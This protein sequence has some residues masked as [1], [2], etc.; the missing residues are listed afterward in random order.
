MSLKTQIRELDVSAN[1][2]SF[3]NIQLFVEKF[4]GAPNTLEVIKME[5]T[6][7]SDESVDLLCLSLRN[8]KSIKL[9]NFSSN[10]ITNR[11]CYA[12]EDMIKG[13]PK[14]EEFFLSSNSI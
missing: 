10:R 12:I 4:N 14:L 3:F 1:T 5:K 8:V 9:I 11:S 7:L 13:L 2:V 6:Q